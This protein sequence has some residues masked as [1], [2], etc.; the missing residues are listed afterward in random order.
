MFTNRTL[1]IVV[2]VKMYFS[3]VPEV[4]LKGETCNYYFLVQ[5]NGHGGC[6]ATIIYSA[7]QINGSVTLAETIG[8]LMTAK[9][10]IEAG[11]PFVVE[12]R[13]TNV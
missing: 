5:G 12:L 6:K 9:E 11:I 4:E 3:L 1:L 7:N 8:K 10:E 13:G 2:N